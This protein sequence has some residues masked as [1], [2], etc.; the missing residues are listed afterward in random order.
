VTTAVAAAAPPKHTSAFRMRRF[1]NWFP[2]GLTYATL[3]MGRYNF[4]VSKGAIGTAYGFDKST[5]GWIATAG[6]WTYA[7]SVLVNGPLAD[8]FGGRRAILVCTAGASFFNLVIGLLFMKG[9][10]VG[11]IAGMSILYSLNMYFQ[12]YGALSVVKVNAA[13]FHVR[14][15]GVLGGVFGSMISAG[16]AL[17]YGVCG[18]ILANAPLWAV[19][20]VPSAVILVMFGVDHFLVRDRPGDA[21]HD[22]FDTGDEK[23]AG[24]E[25]APSFFAVTKHVLSHPVIRRL[26]VA[27]FCT[28][29]VRQGLLLYFPEF[30]AE[31]HGVKTGTGLFQLA[32]WGITVGGIVGA[33]TCGFLSDHFFQ[34]RRAPVAFIFYCGQIV[35]LIVLGSAGS[36]ELA[37]FMV[38]FSCVW[39]FGVHGMLSG[40]ASMDFGGKKAAATAAGLLDGVQYVGAGLTGFGLG[41]ILDVYHWG[42]WTWSIV[43]FSAIGALLMLGLWNAKPR[44]GGGH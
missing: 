32:S 39:I 9:W 38:G 42:V 15:R 1:A 36:K 10:P 26:V 41:K 28:G 40:T 13:W 30:L 18:W 22:D 14:E 16:Y 5:M 7:M 29:I 2:L 8:R 19:Y 21:G 44:A 12:S 34:S 17:A 31:V 27:E 20:V 4:N 25:A 6:F 3:Y 43:P 33:L 37:A 35:S 11:L 24:D 23:V